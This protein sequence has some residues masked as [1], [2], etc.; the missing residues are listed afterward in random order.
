MDTQAQHAKVVTPLPMCAGRGAAGRLG[1]MNIT[2]PRRGD[3]L[4][5]LAASEGCTLL[6]LRFTDLLGR[7]LGTTL[8]A[9]RLGPQARGAFVASS[10]VPGW[11]GLADSD[12]LLRAD[13][14]TRLRDPFA[15][16]PTL[17]AIA[18]AAHPIEIPAIAPALSLL[19]LSVP[20]SA[21]TAKVSTP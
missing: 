16:P 11:M 10:S 12:L 20:S 15:A 4:A 6:D 1:A 5:A 19:L 17:I 7:W 9:S 2:D 21:L 13:P 3:D 14:Q 8:N 18:P